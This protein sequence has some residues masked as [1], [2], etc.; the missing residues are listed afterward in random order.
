MY[1][2]MEHS[3]G[4]A[5]TPEELVSLSKRIEE[6]RI[7]VLC[8]FDMDGADPVSKQHF[9][10]ALSALDQAQCYMKVAALLQSRA[11]M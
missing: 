1:I 4:I 9:F 6:L 10:L 7:S 8:D 3:D 5:Y 2:H 11:L